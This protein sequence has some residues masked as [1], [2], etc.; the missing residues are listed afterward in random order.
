MAGVRVDRLDL[1][2]RTPEPLRDRAPQLQAFTEAQ[3]VPAVLHAMHRRLRTR[4][5][6]AA[7]IRI[8]RLSFH[9]TL[10]PGSL[11]A[12]LVEA[13]AD[14][15]AASVAASVTR[16]H[17]AGAL[18]SPH[19]A[20]QV[21]R[22]AAH[23]AA[24]ALIAAAERRTGPEGVTE[25]FAG[26]WQVLVGEPPAAIARVLARCHAAAGLAVVLARLDLPALVHLE[27]RT[28]SALPPVRAAI[29]A[30]R[31]AT[32]RRAGAE[33]G[34]VRVQPGEPGQQPPT[35]ATPPPHPAETPATPTATAVENPAHAP[36]ASPVKDISALSTQEITAP[37]L[38]HAE[39]LPAAETP[40]RADEPPTPRVPDPPQPL[41]QPL[42]THNA[43]DT[44][45]QNDTSDPDNRVAIAADW[46][47]LLYLVNIFQRLELPERLWQAGVD[48]G[49]ALSAILQLLGGDDPAARILS[50]QFPD[51]PPMLAPIAD[52]A[53]DELT[54]GLTIAAAALV[55]PTLTRPALEAR[56]AAI[57]AGLAAH[58]FAGWAAALTL[59]VFETITDE[60]IAPG[61]LAAHFQRTGTIEIDG[62]AIRI[63]QPMGAIDTG[64]R[65]AGLDADPGW[66]PWLG[67]TLAFVFDDGAA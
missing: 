47:A 15:L 43:L 12:A 44:E 1:R 54:T 27:K 50:P 23:A 5:G 38:R 33:A 8:R 60:T 32:A 19:A 29:H 49:A 53:H 37:Q 46:C 25:D 14:D 9:C 26:L 35:P 28:A 52:W 30:A 11:D 59:A 56:V 21:Y 31:I 66:L 16:D 65:R 39:Q 34:P 24:A 62:D 55:A 4:Y 2:L 7:V 10:H 67:K 57:A 13:L 40:R 48:E 63:V 18:P 61:A 51:A 45:F 6:T 36:N 3:F 41:A 42:P 64:I 22:D 20:A 17:G 58:G